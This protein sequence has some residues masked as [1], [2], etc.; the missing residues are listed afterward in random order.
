MH[1]ETTSWPLKPRAGSARTTSAKSLDERTPLL[2]LICAGG[3]GAMVLVAGLGH[4][5]VLFGRSAWKSCRAETHAVHLLV[6]RSL[7][8]QQS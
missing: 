1:F 6:P 4:Q 7:V 8:N 5:D 3:G 2:C